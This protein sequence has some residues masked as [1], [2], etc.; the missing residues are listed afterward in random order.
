MTLPMTLAKAFAPLAAASFT[1]GLSFTAVG[2]ACL[3]SAGLLWI[4]RSAPRPSFTYVS[5][6]T[7]AE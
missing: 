7:Q 5:A 2:V 1:V 4:T 3:A 6:A